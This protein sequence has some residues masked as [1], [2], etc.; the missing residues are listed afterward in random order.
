MVKEV[1]VTR[2]FIAVITSYQTY[3][4]SMCNP[5]TH[6]ALTVFPNNNIIMV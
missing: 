6:R 4:P 3:E 5:H 2:I 1:I